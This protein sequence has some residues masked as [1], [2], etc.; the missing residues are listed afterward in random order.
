MIFLSS[1]GG[2]NSQVLFLDYVTFLRN[3]LSIYNAK[4][5]DSILKVKRPSTLRQQNMAWKAFQEFIRLK[6]LLPLTCPP[7]QLVRGRW[8]ED[9]SHKSSSWT[10]FLFCGIT[11]SPS[12]MQRSWTGSQRLKDLPL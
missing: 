2:W 3:H 8:E 1:K 12:T 9:G 5:V 4:I 11:S 7:R 10:M 6:K